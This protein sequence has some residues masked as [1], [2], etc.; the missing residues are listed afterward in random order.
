ME[1]KNY[2]KPNIDIELI[3]DVILTSVTVAEWDGQNM[4]RIQ[5]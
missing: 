2:S 1:K 4:D 5:F 3:E